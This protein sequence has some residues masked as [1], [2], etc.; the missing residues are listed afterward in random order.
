[1]KVIIKNKTSFQTIQLENVTSISY[2]NGVFTITAGGA[3]SSYSQTAYCV[4]IL[5]K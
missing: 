1:M 2:S 5:N 4:F 3:T